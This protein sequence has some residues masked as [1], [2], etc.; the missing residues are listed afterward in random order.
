MECDWSADTSSYSSYNLLPVHSAYDAVL[1]LLMGDGSLQS[2]IADLLPKLA[3][4]AS[5]L[6]NSPRRYRLLAM[7]PTSRVVEQLVSRV[8]GVQVIRHIGG[9][10]SAR[11]MLIACR[12]PRMH[13]SLW[14]ELRR[15]LDVRD[16]PATKQGVDGRYVILVLNTHTAARGRSLENKD[17]LIDALKVKYGDRVK[18]FYESDSL[19]DII[20]LFSQVGMR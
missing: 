8:A 13:S 1:P 18:V 12:T 20:N 6:A 10:V 5:L 11:R 16:Q 17:E 14:D 9:L 19:D 15:K 2:T 3:H 4:A 7:P